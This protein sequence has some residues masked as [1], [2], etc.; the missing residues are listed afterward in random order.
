MAKTAK[1]GN[2]RVGDRVR[3]VTPKLFVRCGY[4]LSFDAV[5]AEVATKHRLAVE[6]FLGTLGVMLPASSY[7]G[8][9]QS[10]GKVLKAVAYDLLRQRGHGGKER[11]IYTT[12]KP[13]FA[14]KE[15]AVTAVRF[16]KTGYYCPGYVDYSGDHNPPYLGSEKTHRIL[17]LGGHGRYENTLS[18]PSGGRWREPE[19]EVTN[20][21]RVNPGETT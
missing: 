3:V 18:D 4:P 19:I 6:E 13:E 8:Y 15:Y 14:G 11:S 1:T 21:V 9:P 7:E 5:L 20:V 16:V 10:V 12:E 17:T 2:I